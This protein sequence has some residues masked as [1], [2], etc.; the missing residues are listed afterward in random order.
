MTYEQIRTETRDHVGIIWLN[1]PEKLNAWTDVMHRELEDQIEAWNKDDGIGA[2]ILTGEGR[3]FCAGADLGGF[4]D[5]LS[6]KPDRM[7][8]TRF[9]APW[10]HLMRRSKPII[11]ALNGYAMGVGLTMALPCDFRFAAEGARL[12]IRFV[13]VGLVPE[14]GSTQILSQ[15]VGLGHATDMCLTGRMVDAEEALRMGLVTHVAPADQLLDAALEKA[16]ELAANPTSVVVLIKDLLEKNH[17]E[18]N[19]DAVMEREGVRDRIARKWPEHE[20]AVKAFLEKR[21]PDFAKLAP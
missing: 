10:S 13:K 2:I 18:P 8:E 16:N 7:E 4:S 6:E 20:E 3:A 12:S 19:L 14:L 17:L 21:D 15:L 5:R 1:R 9:S 11:A